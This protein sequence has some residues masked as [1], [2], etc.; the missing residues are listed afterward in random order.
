MT[1]AMKGQTQDPGI[2]TG[3]FENLRTRFDLCI[4]IIS[5]PLP[6]ALP[7]ET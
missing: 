1:V 3:S 5:W 4:H 7:Y 2:A 6:K